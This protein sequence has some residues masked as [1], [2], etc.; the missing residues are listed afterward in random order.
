LKIYLAIP[1]TG[2]ESESFEYVNKIACKLMNQGY[3]VFSPIS[4]T[5][6]IACCGNLPKDWEF[7]KKQDECFI[8]WCDQL[9]VCDFGDWQTSK[10]VR[11]E[12]E[13]A[14]SL[15]K[16]VIHIKSIKKKFKIYEKK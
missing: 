11:A 6:P 2:Q 4:H 16:P 14:K 10:G 8:E 7:W 5:H 15:K 1:Y 13:I 3:I 9:W 12:I